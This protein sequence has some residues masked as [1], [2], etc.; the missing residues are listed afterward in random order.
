MVAKSIICHGIWRVFFPFHVLLFQTLNL[1]LWD[2]F[3]NKLLAYKTDFGE[4]WDKMIPQWPCLCYSTYFGE[5]YLYLLWLHYLNGSCYILRG[6]LFLAVVAC[7]GMDMGHKMGQ[8]E[9]FSKFLLSGPFGE[10][11]LKSGHY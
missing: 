11:S 10:S 6:L 1:A 9:C 3:L 8:E 2:Y 7:H 5:S 4:T